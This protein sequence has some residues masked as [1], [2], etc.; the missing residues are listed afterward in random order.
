MLELSDKILK[1]MEKEGINYP[2]ELY[3]DMKT[4]R[5]SIDGIVSQLTGFTGGK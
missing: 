4:L 2:D 1:G 5:T 3:R